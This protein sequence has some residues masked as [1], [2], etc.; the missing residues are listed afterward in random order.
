[1]SG[2]SSRACNLRILEAELRSAV[3]GIC[4][5]N[6]DAL[7]DHAGILES[8][9]RLAVGIDLEAGSLEEMHAL[10]EVAA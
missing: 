6:P 1:M 5:M 7:R 4:R 10:H 3:R 2:E 8:L 9:S